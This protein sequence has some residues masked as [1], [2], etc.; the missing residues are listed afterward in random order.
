MKRREALLAKDASRP[1]RALYAWDYLL[2]VQDATRQGA[3][4]FRHE[5]TQ[6]FLGA[7]VMA[8]PYAHASVAGLRFSA[9]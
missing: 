4:R 1:A 6:E 8:A 7:E 9:H 5:G 2:G 3:L